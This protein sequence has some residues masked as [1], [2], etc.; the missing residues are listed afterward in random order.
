MKQ[1]TSY[2]PAALKR[3]MGFHATREEE[4]DRLLRGGVLVDLYRVVRQG[5]RISAEGYSIKDIEPLY[6]LNREGGITNAASSIVA[7]EEWLESEDD[8]ILEEIAQ[9]NREDCLSL[10][11]MQAWLENLRKEAWWWKMTICCGL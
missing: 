3:L 11:K 2:E 8:K 10:W 1:T 5:V 6:D 7:Y 9:Y 4:V